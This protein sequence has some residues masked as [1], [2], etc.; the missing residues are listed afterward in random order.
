MSQSHP[1]VSL[2]DRQGVSLTSLIFTRDLQWIFREQ[3][4]SD[5]GIDALVEIVSA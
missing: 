5:V 2:V 1:Q 3:P 4:V